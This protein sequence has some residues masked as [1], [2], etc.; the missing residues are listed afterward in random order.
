MKYRKKNLFFII[1][2]CSLSLHISFSLSMAEDEEMVSQPAEETDVIP[3]QQE[4]AVFFETEGDFFLGYRFVSTDDSLKAAEYIYPQSSLSFGL[5]LLS[6]PLPW[7]YHVNTEFISKHDFYMD[8]GFAYK[9]LLLFRDILVGVHHNLDHYH[10][11]FDPE[12]GLNPNELSLSE[13]YYI[14]FASNLVSLRLKAPD[15]PFHAFL[16]Q[17]HVKRE[18]IIQQRY[19]VGYF[20]DLTM[21]SESRDVEW[22]SDALKLGLNSHLGPIEIEYSYDQ[23]DFDPGHSSILFADYPA[24]NPDPPGIPRPADTYPHN[25]IPE[26]E[27]SAH[28]IRIHSS[29]TGGIVTAATLSHLTQENN[30]SLAESKTLKGAFDFSWIPAPVFGLF[31]KFRH[32]DVDLETPTSV[33]LIGYSDPNNP[34]YY[35]SYPVRQGISYDKNIF[36]LSSRYKPLRHLSL[37]AEYEYSLLSRE[38]SAEWELLSS[39]VKIHTIELAAHARPLDKVALKAL[40]E[41]KNYDQ[42]SYNTTPDSSNKL[43]LS[44]NYI[45]LPWLNIYLEYLLYLTDQEPLKYLIGSD[46]L[47][48]GEREGRQDQALASITTTI[49]PKLSMTFSWFY[50]RW[51]VE[52]DLLYGSWPPEPYIFDPG[53]PYTDK[54]NSFSIGL[55]WLPREDFTLDFDISYT[56]AE[57]VTDYDALIGGTDLSLSSFSHL[58]TEETGIS[59]DLTK[60]LSREWEVGLRSYMNIYNDKTSGLLNL[61]GNVF[62]TTFLVKRYF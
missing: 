46:P 26:T 25:V 11:L 2:A 15:F 42:P 35:F 55:Q 21:T 41:Y 5:N 16:N 22:E 53:V 48:I 62:T 28:T 30:Y 9:D 32:T 44:T 47:E 33:P 37:F 54:A 14:D 7:R 24:Y 61:D 10:F 51:D 56:I 38:N 36:S 13:D 4:P 39:Q 19:L 34:T 50:Q 29:Y 17:R 27:T 43:K 60:K 6:C 59:L 52:Q 45:P 49:S 20:D 57:G 1:F 12:P 40:Y 8:A 58:N 23:S 31:F 18:G 3:E